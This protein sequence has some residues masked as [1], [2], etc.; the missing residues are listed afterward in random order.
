MLLTLPETVCPQRVRRCIAC[1]ASVAADSRVKRS[2]KRFLTRPRNVIINEAAVSGGKRKCVSSGLDNEQSAIVD[3]A[4]KYD[5]V[6]VT[7][8]QQKFAGQCVRKIGQFVPILN[9]ENAAAWVI[10]VTD[11]HFNGIE[12]VASLFA[13]AVVDTQFSVEHVHSSLLRN[14]LAFGTSARAKAPECG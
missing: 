6:S 2:K 13:A 11:S 14:E 1:N 12:S 9:D 3:I 7:L 4:G 10:H 8:L 5:M